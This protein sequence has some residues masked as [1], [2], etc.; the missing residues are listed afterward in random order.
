M[1]TFG[2]FKNAKKC[3]EFVCDAC[4]FTCFKQS[5]YTS[6][7]ATR[8]HKMMTNDD[9]MMTLGIKKMPKQYTCECGKSYAHRQGLHVHILKCPIILAE[10]P[11]PAPMPVPVP[12]VQTQPAP[13]SAPS[14][15]LFAKLI[16]QNNAFM[17]NVIDKVVDVVAKVVKKDTMSHSH[18]TTNSHNKTFNLQFFLN[19]TCKD[20]MNISDFVKNLQISTADFEKI[21]DLGYAE[22]ISR[23][24]INGL[25][26][27]DVSKR[28][29]HCSDLKREIIHIKDQDRWEKDTPNQDKLKCVIQKISN[30]NMMVMDDWRN[31]NPG[32]KEYDN[33][34][35]DLYLKLLT[36]SIGPMDVVSS[37]REFKKITKKIATGTIIDKSNLVIA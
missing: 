19:D 7:L 28:P 27:L 5:N 15:V 8:K 2:A 18:N 30:K 24:F 6:H 10:V 4:D 22:G 11:P 21:G 33:C 26:E 3:Q 37:E 12:D 36:E 20:A 14:E 29:I 25:N 9:K 34:K 32:C 31:E 13:S 1:M 17:E 35:N 23:L 16:E